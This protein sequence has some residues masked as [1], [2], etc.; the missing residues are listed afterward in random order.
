LRSLRPKKRS[1]NTQSIRKERKAL[2]GSNHK[3]YCTIEA[4][5]D[6]CQY[7]PFYYVFHFFIVKKRMRWPNSNHLVHGLRNHVNEMRYMRSLV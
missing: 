3:R 2:Q 4:N 1:Q 5:N 7:G 6:K